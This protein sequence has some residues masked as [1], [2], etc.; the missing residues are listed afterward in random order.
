MLKVCH[1]LKSR[2]IDIRT[3]AKETLVK[4]AQ[5]LGSRYLPYIVKEMKT[6]LTRGYQVLTRDQKL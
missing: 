4:I 1:F 5:S 3:A 2:S 6:T